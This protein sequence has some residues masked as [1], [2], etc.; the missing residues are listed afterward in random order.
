MFTTQGDVWWDELAAGKALNVQH[1][2][3]WTK[4][5]YLAHPSLP[6]GFCPARSTSHV[7]E[8]A[9]D[10]ENSCP[11]TRRLQRYHRH[12]WAKRRVCVAYVYLE[13]KK[14]TPLTLTLPGRT[15]PAAVSD[16]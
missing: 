3:E 5:C 11:P 12:D 16:K 1:F 10:L 14:R 6:P 9:Q 2:Q 4:L 8:P 13:L 15:G 7:M